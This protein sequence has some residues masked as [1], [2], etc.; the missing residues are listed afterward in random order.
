MKERFAAETAHPAGNLPCVAGAITQ[1][2]VVVDTYAG[3]VKVDWDPEAKVTSLGNFAYFVEYLKT[4]GL[5][6]ALVT[7]A[8]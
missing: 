8:R 2:P 4:G 1:G 3:P 7:I 5:F 6:D